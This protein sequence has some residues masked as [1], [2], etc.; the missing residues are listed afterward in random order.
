[1]PEL[2]GISCRYK[3][4]LAAPEKVGT[5][6]SLLSGLLVGSVQIGFLGSYALALWYGGVRIRDGAYDGEALRSANLHGQ[7]TA[8][9]PPVPLHRWL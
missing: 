3:K 5:R 6:S 2:H 4:C 9:T 1:M 7:R 8:A